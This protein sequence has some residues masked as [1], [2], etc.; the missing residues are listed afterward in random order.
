M[1]AYSQPMT[2]APTTASVRG[3]WS[4]RRMS[5]LVMIRWPS[6]GMC[7]SIVAS[8]PVAMTTLAVRDQPL[9]AAIDV[10]ELDAYAR[11]GTKPSAAISSTWLRV[12]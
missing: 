10:V 4:S 2:P 12:S 3:R 1:L 5:S 9:A 11:H 8:V 7:G 6:N